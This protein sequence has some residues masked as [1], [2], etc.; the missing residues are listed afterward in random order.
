M[1]GGIDFGGEVSHHRAE[2]APMS[3]LIDWATLSQPANMMV[4]LTV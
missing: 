3:V 4:N 2:S 1:S